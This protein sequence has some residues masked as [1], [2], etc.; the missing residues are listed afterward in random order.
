MQADVRILI[1]SSAQTATLLTQ[2]Y[3][4]SFLKTT[5][6]HKICPTVEALLRHAKR[7]GTVVP[8]ATL[9]L[10]SDITMYGDVLLLYGGVVITALINPLCTLMWDY[11][12]IWVHLFLTRAKLPFGQDAAEVVTL[13]V[14][15]P[16]F[17][18][19]FWVTATL[20]TH[21]VASSIAD[22]CVWRLFTAGCVRG[23]VVSFG[24]LALRPQAS[25]VTQTHTALQRAI[26]V[27]T[28]RASRLGR[29]LTWAVT[30][31]IDSHLQCV[32]KAQRLDA[33]RLTL[34]LRT[35]TELCF[36]TERNLNETHRNCKT[37]QNK[38]KTKQN[39]T[40]FPVRSS[41]KA[42]SKIQVAF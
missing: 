6:L 15:A 33:E 22:S 9:H 13:A 5:E 36:Y 30:C 17:P 21:T 10:L 41:P 39:K 28:G 38:T 7:W 14:F 32:F 19:V 4:E 20:A 29:I 3:S 23:L 42:T 16:H 37:R 2:Q 25:W 8:T 34:H 11:E 24:A 40:T 27:V 26:A 18:K 35:A 31:K 12:W 1:L